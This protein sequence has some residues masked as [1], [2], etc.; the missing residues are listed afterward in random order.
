MASV[1]N[2][3]TVKSSDMKDNMQKF[4]MFNFI[5]NSEKVIVFIFFLMREIA[6]KALQETPDNNERKIAAYIK[7]ALGF[8]IWLL[9]IFFFCF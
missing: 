3:I 7:N 1:E 8:R 4:A 6:I 2:E 9:I 5:S